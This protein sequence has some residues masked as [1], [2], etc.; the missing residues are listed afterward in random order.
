MVTGTKRHAPYEYVA[1]PGELAGL[2]E[3]MAHEPLLGVDTE[4]ASFHRYVDRIYLIQ[5]SSR[6]DTAIIDPLTV[7]DGS[8][9]G[10]LLADK[11]IEVIFHDADYDLRILDRD[12]GIRAR[13]LFDTRIAAQL[14]GEPAI[15]LAALLEKYLQVKLDKKH[16]R[17]DWSR[18]PLT[19]DMLD[20][21]AM[22]TKHL[23]AL[24][25]ELRGQLEQMGRLSWAEEEFERLEDLRWT[26][27][28]NNNGDSYLRI[29]G[30]RLLSRRALA[31]LKELTHWRDAVAAELDR[32]SFR[33]MSNET[34]LALAGTPPENMDV[35]K[36]GIAGVSPRLV[37]QRGDAL[38]AAIER[39]QKVNE[40]DLP[41]FPRGERRMAD[42]AF[43]ERVEKLK[44]ARNKAAERL[45][46]DPGVLCPKGTLEAVARAKP[47]TKADLAHIP[48]VRKWQAE[49]L[50]AEFLGALGN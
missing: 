9:L 45:K 15:G 7:G 31:L 13:N 27:V 17:A 6:T 33:V 22:D 48:E 28:A 35:L 34:L 11:K 25:D 39:G 36:K 10:A 14:L 46:L 26:P 30:A 43:D 23:P 42:P 41:R 16:Q 40:K 8:A 49:V 2:V 4:A 32:A 18:R 29:K 5:L 47:K 1:S 38:M 20:Y 21:A 37:E 24:R 12:Y 50:G 44:T 19:P 3:R